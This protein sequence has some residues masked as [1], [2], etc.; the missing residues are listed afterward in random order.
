MIQLCD[1]EIILNHTE[2]VHVCLTLDDFLPEL[3]N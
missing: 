2:R 3:T 1:S